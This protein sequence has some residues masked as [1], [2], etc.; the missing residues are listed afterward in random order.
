MKKLYLLFLIL[1]II[2]SAN[3]TILDFNVA[4]TNNDS[5]GTLAVDTQPVY[6]SKI[7]G[8]GLVNVNMTDADGATQEQNAA[9]YAEPGSEGA[10]PDIV[11][12]WGSPTKKFWDIGY[13][14]LTNVAYTNVSGLNKGYLMAFNPE[15][16]YKV[17]I[18]SLKVA[19]WFTTSEA[20]FRLTFEDSSAGFNTVYDSG[21]VDI[22]PGDGHVILEPDFTGESEQSLWMTIE[23]VSTSSQED[24]YLLGVDDIV[25]SQMD[26]AGSCGDNGYLTSDISGPDGIPDCYVD[27]YDFAQIAANW[28]D[29]TDP[30]NVDCS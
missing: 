1:F 28:L 25:F 23:L 17:K 15:A 13:G 27:I 24:T 6:G 20:Q 21:L 16:G 19:Y 30:N 10:T 3:A 2:S 4:A 11:M 7:T 14:D 26:A 18:H 5:F 8:A 22:N 9:T 29:C 12:T